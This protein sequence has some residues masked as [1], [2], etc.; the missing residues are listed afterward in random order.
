MPETILP[1][2]EDIDF[3]DEKEN[4]SVKK[5]VIFN[6]NTRDL[7]RTKT[8]DM[9]TKILAVPSRNGQNFAKL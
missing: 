2:K 6:Y 5:A 3:I 9:M 8:L 7:E 1:Q 4:D